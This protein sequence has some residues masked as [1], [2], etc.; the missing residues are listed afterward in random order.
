MILGPALF[1]FYRMVVCLG[2][3][4]LAFNISDLGSDLYL[5]FMLQSVVELPAIIICVLLLDRVG[6][7]P[8]MAGSML[9]GGFALVGTIFTLIYLPGMLPV[10]PLFTLMFT[11]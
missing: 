2:Y 10:M 6:R 7:K 1:V 4:G 11:T 8:V 3:Y 5:N 9:I